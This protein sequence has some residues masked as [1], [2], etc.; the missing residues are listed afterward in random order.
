[1]H[2]SRRSRL[3][4]AKKCTKKRDARAEV[5]V[6]YHWRDVFAKSGWKVNGKW[7]F[8]SSQWK[9]SESNGKSQ[10][11]VRIFRTGCSKR[12]FVFDFFKANFDTSFRLSRQFF[13]KWNWFSTNGKRD[14][15]RKVP[16]L[17]FDYQFAHVSGEQA[18]FCQS[19]PIAI[20]LFSLTSPS[21]QAV[22]SRKRFISS[23]FLV[24]TTQHGDEP[25]QVSPVLFEMISL[26]IP[27]AHK[28]QK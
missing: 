7:L 10:N 2:V 28:R 20:L 3:V 1:M 8:E 14:S 24:Q 17:N 9:I 6:V 13:E 19:E 16:V 15:R 12:K 23:S 26:H 18:L 4:K 21:S 27:T 5:L 25:G 11:V 22:K